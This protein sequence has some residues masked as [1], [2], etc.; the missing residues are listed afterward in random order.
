[1]GHATGQETLTLKGHNKAVESGRLAPTASGCLRQSGY[2]GKTV[3]RRDSAG[4]PHPQGAV[5]QVKS[6][7][8]SPDGPPARLRQ[9]RMTV[10]VWTP[11]RWTP[12]HRKPGPTLLNPDRLKIRPQ[13]S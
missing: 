11:G 12:A 8:L 4:N 10:K 13:G 5:S 3:G 6:V 7:V 9:S 2:D 1:M